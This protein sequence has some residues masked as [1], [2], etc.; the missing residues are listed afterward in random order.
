MGG[1]YSV[2]MAASLDLSWP[3]SSKR[4]NRNSISF[5]V[6]SGVEHNLWARQSSPLKVAMTVCGF[7][8]DCGFIVIFVLELLR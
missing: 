6:C 7:W 3:L 5:W 2:A 4:S 8:H 1:L